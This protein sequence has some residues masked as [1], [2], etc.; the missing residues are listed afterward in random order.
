MA[1]F[2]FVCPMLLLFTLFVIFPI[3]P[4]IIISL[5]NNDG[6]TSKGFVGIANYKGVLGDKD[7][8]LANLNNIK[9]IVIEVLI[10]LPLSFILALVINSQT[11]GIRRFFKMGSFLPS[12]LSV[13]VI[14]QMWIGIYEPQWGLLNS[15]MKTIGLGGLAHEWLSDEGTALICVAVAFLWQFVGFNMLLFYTGLK[16]IPTTY[17]EAS[18]IDGANHFQS[19][20]KITIPLLQEITKYLLL[21]STLG[22]MAQFAHIRIMT[23]GGPGGASNTV[24]YYLYTQAFT[25]SDFGKGCAISVLFVIEC[26]IITFIINQCV[27]KEKLQY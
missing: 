10:G 7:F 6:F 24:V 22:C 1:I 13:T 2:I 19:T 5:Q 18:V 17:Y 4:S 8:W 16:S 15:L 14:S 25:A 21:I 26:L 23:S 9:I 20:I 12:V 11:S 27:A 3:V